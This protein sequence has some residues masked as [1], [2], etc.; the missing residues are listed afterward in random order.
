MYRIVVLLSLLFIIGC[1]HAATYETGQDQRQYNRDHYSCRMA[2][3]HQALSGIDNLM[4]RGARYNECMDAMG[5]QRA[6]T[7]EAPATK[8][9]QTQDAK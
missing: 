1:S 5:Y 9:S 6:S 8:T 2:A 4:N 7:P 3:Q